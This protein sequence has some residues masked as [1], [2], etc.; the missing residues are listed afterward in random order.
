L[1]KLGVDALP[2][3][4]GWLSNGEKHVLKTRISVKDLKSA[5]DDSMLLDGFEKKNKKAGARMAQTSRGFVK[6][7]LWKILGLI[8]RPVGFPVDQMLI[9]SGFLVE[10]MTAGQKTKKKQK[11]ISYSNSR[12]IEKKEVII[13]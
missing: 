10:A 11:I 3:I 6:Q 9:F 5:V 8:Y 13:N 1:R 2:A 7:D 4:V 12:M